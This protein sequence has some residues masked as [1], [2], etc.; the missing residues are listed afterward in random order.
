MLNEYWILALFPGKF[1]KHCRVMAE[2]VLEKSYAAEKAA[3]FCFVFFTA[4]KKMKN[5][6]FQSSI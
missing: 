6:I 1:A 4:V 3:F 2:P 5:K